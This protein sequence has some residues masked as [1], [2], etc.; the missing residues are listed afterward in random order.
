MEKMEKM[1]S[2]WS[3]YENECDR[4]DRNSDKNRERDR[5][6]N[7]GRNRNSDGDRRR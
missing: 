1:E 4:K 2:N 6:L 7:R 5:E 3:R